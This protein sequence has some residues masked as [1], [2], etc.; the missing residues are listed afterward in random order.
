MYGLCDTLKCVS[1]CSHFLQT[2]ADTLSSPEDDVII[3]IIA[4]ANTGHHALRSEAGLY[5]G[6]WVKH[7]Q[8]GVDEH[9]CY[10]G[11]HNTGAGSSHKIGAARPRA[12]QV[13]VHRA[14]SYLFAFR[15]RRVVAIVGQVA[16]EDVEL[17]GD[18]PPGVPHLVLV[19][20]GQEDPELACGEGGGRHCGG[21]PGTEPTQGA[22]CH[23]GKR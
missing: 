7:A 3:E 11:S 10:S 16:R 21:L 8:Q 5:E 4:A 1:N 20:G 2:H 18:H 12:V 19:L 13:P 14:F 17:A 15:R 6:P 22:M 23:L 9:L